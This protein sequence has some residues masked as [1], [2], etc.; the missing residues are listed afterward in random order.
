MKKTFEDMSLYKLT[1]KVT[2]TFGTDNWKSVL[3]I[4]EIPFKG[5]IR[6]NF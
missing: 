3:R 6:V 5:A 4:K 2:I 1:C